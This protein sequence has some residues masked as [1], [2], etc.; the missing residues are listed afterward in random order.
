MDWAKPMDA[1]GGAGG[2]GPGAAAELAQVAAAVGVSHVLYWWVWYW[3]HKWA[4]LCARVRGPKTDPVDVLAALASL[5]RLLQ[6]ILSFWLV[7]K[8]LAPA[9]APGA[10]PAAWPLPKLLDC[11]L[12]AGAAVGA[13]GLAL[14]GCGQALN[15]GIYHAI[16]KEGVYYGCKLGKDIPWCE[17]F[18]FNVCGHPQYMGCVLSLWGSFLPI[19]LQGPAWL[20]ALPGLWTLFYVFSGAVESDGSAGAVPKMNTLEINWPA[21]PPA[22]KKRAPKKKRR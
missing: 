17:G 22:R 12:G 21:G 3:P 20:A 6:F 5:L 4:A 13:A 16:G 1:G 7:E 9:A 14:F 10:W 18:P 8:H 2:P 15:M 11:Y 19:V